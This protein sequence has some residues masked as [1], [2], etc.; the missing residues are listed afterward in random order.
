MFRLPL[1]IELQ[2]QK[3]WDL[4]DFGL[5]LHQKSFLVLSF[6]LFPDQKP[7]GKLLI[8]QRL[9]SNFRVH[10]LSL[11][12]EE[13]S[14]FCCILS[15]KCVFH[16]KTDSLP[17]KHCDCLKTPLT[18]FHSSHYCRILCDQFLQLFK[19]GRLFWRRLSAYKT[20]STKPTKHY[21]L[22]RRLLL[23]VP[24]KSCP[25]NRNFCVG[26]AFQVESFNRILHTGVYCS[27]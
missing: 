17:V 20:L 19:N 15:C 27:I 1:R 12:S 9:S 22:G 2:T 14:A 21:L 11:P 18:D 13:W 4:P 23:E 7:I 6:F 26:V 8:K 16:I 10:F 24:T 5:L 25:I 3:S